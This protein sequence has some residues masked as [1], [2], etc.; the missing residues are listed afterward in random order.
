NIFRSNH[1][2]SALGY[3]L[4]E[5]L[6]GRSG[7]RDLLK[8]YKRNKG[9]RL[10]QESTKGSTKEDEIV[11]SQ[12]QGKKTYIPPQLTCLVDTND[13]NGGN[14]THL[15]ENSSGGAIATGS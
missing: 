13:I 14:S 8:V 4:E 11:D 15:N 10:M 1:R 3:E 12:R 5:M 2:D 9:V 6:V 7:L